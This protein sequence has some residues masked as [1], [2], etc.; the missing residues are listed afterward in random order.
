MAWKSE[1]TDRRMAADLGSY[2]ADA[3]RKGETV[4]RE[5]V[6]VVREGIFTAARQEQAGEYPPKGHGYPSSN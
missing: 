6:D 5:F 3:A 1:A 2:H 4:D